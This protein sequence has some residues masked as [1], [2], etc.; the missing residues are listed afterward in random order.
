MRRR[1]SARSTGA[2]CVVNLVGILAERRQGRIRSA[3]MPRAPG[4]I[5]RPA[6]AAG[7]RAWCMSRRSGPTRPAQPATAATKAAGEAAV[8]QAFP[9]ATIMRPAIVFGPEDQFFNRF[10]G[11]AQLC[12]VMP[13]IG[14]ADALPAGLCRRCRRCGDGGARTGGHG[15][16][17]A[18]SWAARGSGRF[19]E[20]LAYILTQTGATAAD[21]E[22]ADGAGPVAGAAVGTA[23]RSH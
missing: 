16:R 14:G 2:D 12:P 18:T 6:A 19:R 13:V 7:V 15:G 5:A 20:I 22:C 4:A 3:S 17:R 21:A 8:R 23:A 10:A 9:A 11:M 1:C